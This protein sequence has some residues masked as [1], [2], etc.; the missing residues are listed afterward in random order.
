MNVLPSEREPENNL[1]ESLALSH[2]TKSTCN[3]TLIRNGM[4]SRDGSSM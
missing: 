2:E 4:G 1:I 3:R